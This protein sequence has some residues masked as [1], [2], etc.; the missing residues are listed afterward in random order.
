MT[1]H[2]IELHARSAFSFLEGAAL[3]LLCALKPEEDT[4]ASTFT[5]PILSLFL[6]VSASLR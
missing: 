6:C 3:C 5:P 2:Y 4:P 1:D